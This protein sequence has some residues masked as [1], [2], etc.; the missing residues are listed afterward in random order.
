MFKCYFYF[1]FILLSVM[2]LPAVYIN[3][4]ERSGIPLGGLGTGYI[5]LLS[6][7][8]FGKS[9]VQN[10]FLSP[11]PLPPGCYLFLETN[12]L[13]IPLRTGSV[14]KIVLNGHF[15][16]ADLSYF[17]PKLP[18]PLFLKAFSPFIKKDDRNSSLPT[19]IF[20]FS[21]PNP[22]PQKIKIGISW[23]VAQ[24][25][26]QGN[27]AGVLSWK[28]EI[29]YPQAE[30]ICISAIRMGGKIN[31]LPPSFD[32]PCGRE[33]KKIRDENTEMEIGKWGAFNWEEGK[34]FTLPFSGKG[35]L[36]AIFHSVHWEGGFCGTYYIPGGIGKEN[37][38]LVD[39]D[40]ISEDG[41]CVKR[42]LRSEDGKLEIEITDL[43]DDGV[44]WRRVRLKNIA[45]HPLK[46]LSFSLFVNI[47]A[48]GI[49]E[50]ENNIG[51]VLENGSLLLIS[52][53]EGRYPG[54]IMGIGNS[55]YYLG[56]W[57]EALRRA[58]ENR[59]IPVGKESQ[60]WIEERESGLVFRSDEG[61]YAIFFPKEYKVGKKIEREKGLVWAEWD[62]GKQRE[63]WFVLSWFFPNYIS[64]QGQVLGH[65]YANNFSS[66]EEVAEY[67]LQ[68]KEKWLKKIEAWQKEIY[69]LP[70][71]DWLKDALINGL[72]P[73][74]KNS[75]YIKDGRF[76]LSESFTGCP[77]N[78]TLVCRFNGSFPLLI[79]FP[80]LEKKVIREFA[81]LQKE[82]GEIPF[83]FGMGDNFDSPVYHLQHPIVSTEFI[84][85]VWRDY[86]WTKD[87]AFLKELYPSVKKALQFARKLDKNGDS[88]I[89]E[90]PQ[91]GGLA[92]QYYDVWE[93]QGVSSYVN[94]ILLASLKAVAKMAEIMEDE[95][96]RRFAEE[97]FEKAEREFQAR[98]WNGRWFNLYSG[99][100]V[101]ET[102]LANQL[103]GQWYAY[104]TGLGEI[105]PKE[106]IK[107]AIEWIDK[108]NCEASPYGV[109]NGVLPNGKPDESGR[110][111]QSDGISPGEGFAFS[112][113]AIFAGEE[114]LGLT[115]SEKIYRNIAHLRKSPW[116]IYFNYFSS[117]GEECWG[118]DYY[119]N[120]S[121]WTILIA[122]KGG[123][124]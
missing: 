25:K 103:V 6:N 15:S 35:N 65:Y 100:K 68:N 48:G 112:A 107:S 9:T 51:E 22:K 30:M 80:R 49:E 39:G 92:N 67:S 14:E 73:L 10:N 3:G 89:E 17:D 69:S 50:A 37:L 11:L 113:T 62:G 118:S 123:K 83:C 42:R 95:E 40:K 34:E 111:H 31:P 121:V 19:I 110:N 45:N 88:L 74:V 29:L 117:T 109:V 28:K 76:S 12:G 90:D 46:N 1:I 98:L 55:D 75:L 87:S 44:L 53:K 26:K 8:C 93:W 47:D 84:L 79:F 99:E 38:I 64:T 116:N 57:Q 16:I 61:E 91:P 105:L 106:R 122:L 104:L 82:D 97:W 27:L 33:G 32:L 4:E 108:L 94:S 119:S 81:R 124:I 77:I 71:P 7:G 2:A 102:C 85:M 70:Y 18:F 58:G 72:Y 54:Y 43:L 36:S 60:W 120:M 23:E 56:P 52:D 41:R 115:A 59:L 86:V 5:E 63:I 24:G 13:H 101:S 66:A 21:S 20:R 114:R 96:T 78:E